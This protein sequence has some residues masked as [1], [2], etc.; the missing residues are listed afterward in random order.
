MEMAGDRDARAQLPIVL[1]ELAST[2]KMLDQMS[3]EA[4]ERIGGASATP[5]IVPRSPGSF[6]G[7]A[8]GWDAGAKG[9]RVLPASGVRY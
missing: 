5:H 3:K 4:A 1:A 6:R 8:A 2:R 9:T 7:A